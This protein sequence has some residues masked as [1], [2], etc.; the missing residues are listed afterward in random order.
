MKKRQPA[1]QAEGPKPTTEY[2][3]KTIFNG[4]PMAEGMP[5]NFLLY[6][7][8]E[9][10]GFVRLGKLVTATLWLQSQMVALIC[11]NENAELRRQH[12]VDHGKGFPAALH[13]AATRK[14]EV[15]SSESLRRE[16][17]RC[18]HSQMSV[19]VRSDLERVSLD[20]DGLIH[21]YVAL[22]N[23]ITGPGVVLWAPHRSPSR[24]AALTKVVGN[25]QP[26]ILAFNLSADAYQEEIER[27]CRKMDFIASVL[28]Q[29]DIPYMVFA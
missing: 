14:L 5:A 28:K 18:F 6:L 1:P 10:E 24:D 13:N 21:G 12:T 22:F 25:Q 4:Q 3:W 26:D 9:K 23:Q 8:N 16:F 7:L 27:I 19:D 29:W 20:R 15:L 17:T 2:G 11:V